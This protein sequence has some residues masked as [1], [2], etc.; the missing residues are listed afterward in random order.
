[1]DPNVSF[2]TGEIGLLKPT[3]LKAKW[4]FYF[5]E[6]QAKQYLEIHKWESY[7]YYVSNTETYLSPPSISNKTA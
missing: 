6:L 1:M 2:A 3:W 5:S 4:A 7:I